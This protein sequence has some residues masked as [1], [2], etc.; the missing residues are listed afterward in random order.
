MDNTKPVYYTNHIGIGMTNYDIT[1]TVAHRMGP[2][3]PEEQ[4]TDE[5]IK[6]NIVMSPQHA[7][8]FANILIENIRQYEELFGTITVEPNFE[9]YNAL[10]NSLQK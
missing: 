10:M 4:I 8:A 1:M 5:Q 7:K 2:A 9:K 3:E 6:C